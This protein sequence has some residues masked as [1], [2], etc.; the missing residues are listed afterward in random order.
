[1]PYEFSV[2]AEKKFSDPRIYQLEAMAL[3]R[4]FIDVAEAIGFDAF[5]TMWKI[6]S[7]DPTFRDQGPSAMRIVM[8]PIDAFERYQR[9]RYIEYLFASGLTDAE[10]L[11]RLDKQLG[12]DLADSSVRRLRNERTGRDKSAKKHVAQ[13]GRKR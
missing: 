13:R 11:D 8:R 9:N 5:M 7:A 3:R 10:V 4:T 1:M 6:F 12:V 2:P